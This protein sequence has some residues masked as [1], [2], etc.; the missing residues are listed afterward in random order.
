MSAISTVNPLFLVQLNRTDCLKHFY[1]LC[2][3]EV[4]QAVFFLLNGQVKANFLFQEL[5]VFFQYS[6]AARTVVVLFTISM[7]QIKY[8]HL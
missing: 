1:N 4:F 5:W 7:L 8:D 3:M 2:R 6:E